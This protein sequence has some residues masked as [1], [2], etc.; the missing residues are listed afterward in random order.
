M[1]YF[2]YCRKS[3]ESSERQ[4]LSIPAQKRE[5]KEYAVQNGLKIIKTYSEEKSAM[6]PGRRIQF[7]EMIKQ[8]EQGKCQRIL[9]WAMNR[10]S[11]NALENG[12]IQQLV[13]DGK[14]AEIRTPNEVIE[15]STANDILMGVQMGSNSQFSKELSRNTKRGIREKIVRGQYPSK[16]P[17]F[18]INYGFKNH[19]KNIK[20]DPKY[21]KYY[22]P[23]IDQIIEKR[24]STPQA[25][26]LL[27]EM[28][29]RNAKGKP[30]CRNTVERALKNPVYCGILK[31]ADY[32]ETKGKWEPLVSQSK[33]N[34]LQAVLNEKSKPY[35]TKREHAFKRLAVCGIC[36]RAITGYT[37]TKKNG[38]EYTYYTC[39]KGGK[40]P[41]PQINE[42]DLEKQFRNYLSKVKLTVRQINKLREL[43]ISKLESEHVY[44]IERRK[45]ID[46]Q[47]SEVNEKLDN[48]LDMRMGGELSKDEFIGSKARLKNK[49]SELEEMRNDIAYNREEVREAFER[50][51]EGCLN[52]V[53]TFNK[54]DLQ[55]KRQIIYAIS[56]NIELNHKEIR[57]NFKKPWDKAVS[58]NLEPENIEWGGQNK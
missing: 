52:L 26:A 9:V 31:Y 39:S 3:S 5:L 10:L 46:K 8:V 54:A 50:F 33:W 12:I 34:K 28:G 37:K 38:K 48:L 35:Q 30:Y 49:L 42:D 6:K 53:K 22:E 7:N 51:F 13:N 40:C 58:V 32:D 55:E 24:L 20:P 19:N 25:H 18:Y 21:S 4:A 14:L 15:S 11:R 1:Q 16:A 45:D 56:E 44:D 36:G 47:I 2:M 23:W 17:I 57:L 41:N 29:V 27:K 43:S